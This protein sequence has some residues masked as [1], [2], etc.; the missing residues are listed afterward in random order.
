MRGV[1]RMNAHCAVFPDPD[2][3]PY[4]GSGLLNDLISL[5]TDVN[6]PTVRNKQKNIEK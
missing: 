5:K 1:Y 2:T 6:V 4:P 3:D